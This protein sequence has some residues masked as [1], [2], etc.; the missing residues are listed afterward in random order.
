MTECVLPGEDD[1]PPMVVAGS[2]MPMLLHGEDRNCMAHSVETQLPSLD[3]HLAGVR[4]G[5]FLTVQAR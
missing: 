4:A 2:S 1:P 5:I 3:Y